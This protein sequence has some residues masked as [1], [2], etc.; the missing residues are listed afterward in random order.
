MTQICIIK[1]ESGRSVAV[2][3]WCWQLTETENV[4]NVA[5]ALCAKY[6]K[7]NNDRRAETSRQVPGSRRK[8]KAAVVA[9]DGMRNTYKDY[10]A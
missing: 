7:N 4:A 2:R 3:C 1:K 9:L 10:P 6:V 5:L 8:E